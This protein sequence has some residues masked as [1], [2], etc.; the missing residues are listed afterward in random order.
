MPATAIVST[1][2]ADYGIYRPLLRALRDAGATVEI[3]AGGSHLSSAHGHTIDLIRADGLAQVRPVEHQTGGDGDLDLARSAGEAVAG[4]AA[5]IAEGRPELVFV[6]GD[7]YEMLAAGLG[8][9]ITRTPIA[10]LHGGDVTEG[11]YDEQFRHALTKLSHLHFPSIEE[12]AARILA[13]GEEPWRVHVVG[14]LAL[15]EL[16]AFKP[17]PLDLL[18]REAGFDPAWTAAPTVV[19]LYHPETLADEPPAAA[20]ARVAQGLA[21]FD[22]NVLVVGGNADTGHLDLLR[23]MR[24]WASRRP[25]TVFVPA[26]SPARFWSWLT[27]AAVLVGN[28]SAGP[29]E[30]ASFRLP[31]INIGDRQHGR[32]RAANV[33][34][35][36]CDASAIAAALRRALSAEFRASLRGLANPY[37]DG[38]AAGRIIA[39]IRNLPPRGQLLRKRWARPSQPAP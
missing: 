38:R 32:M 9:A 21:G 6:L 17:E 27:H 25:R 29:I 33:I 2:R 1:S 11:A 18:A 15:D 19:V 4:F 37:G 30:A 12:H 26:L 5:A 31:V 22:G 28:S 8:A 10:H 20:F 36:P 13:M 34:D 23:D 14:A 35:V 7:R 16:A 3:L 39:A 24:T